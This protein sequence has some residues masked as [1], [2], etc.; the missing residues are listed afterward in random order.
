MFYFMMSVDCKNS[1]A[2]KAIRVHQYMYYLI[3]GKCIE[4]KA[5]Y[6]VI[7]TMVALSANTPGADGSLVEWALFIFNKYST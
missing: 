2:K 3:Y 1:R 7:N 4:R 5:G 6:D